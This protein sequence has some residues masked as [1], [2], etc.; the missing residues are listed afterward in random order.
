M[1]RA[2]L[3]SARTLGALFAGLLLAAPAAAAQN[4][5]LPFAPGEVCVYRGSNGLGRIGSGTMAVD[6]GYLLRFDFRGRVGPLGVYDRSRSWLDPATLSSSHYTKHERTPISS[7]D[8]DVRMDAATGRWTAA[9]GRGGPMPTRA[10]LDELSFLY[11]VRTL[12]LAEGDRYTF[13]RHFDPARNPVVVRVTGRGVTAVPAG[14]FQTVG[15]EM[16]VRDAARYRGEGVIQLR[17]TDDAR[18]ILVRMESNIPRAG[19]MVLSL[20]SG[21]GG[22]TPSPLPPAR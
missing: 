4:A 1:P 14:R 9:G 2:L 13:A 5:A 12:P 18:R 10:P 17:L 7:R 22:C 11:F 8:E 16:R 19:R 15:V 3:A 6:D 21:T 20:E